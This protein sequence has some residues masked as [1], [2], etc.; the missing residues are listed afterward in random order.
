MTESARRDGAPHDVAWHDVDES[1]RDRRC[2]HCG[3]DA[4]GARYCCYG[5]ELAQQL[6]TE[7]HQ[8]RHATAG[9]LTL[10]LLLAMIVMMMSLF[11]YAEDIYEATNEPVF[12]WLRSFYRWVSAGLATPVVLMLGVPLGRRAW[13]RLT[14]RAIT[15]ELLIV[16]GAV[17]AWLVSMVAVV[18]GA[19]AVY[20]D[21]AVAALVLATFGRYL[22]AKARARA[23]H[24]V[25]HLL[26][27]SARPVRVGDVEMAPAAIEPGME[28][29]VGPEQVVPVDGRLLAPVEVSLGVLTGESSP[30]ALRQGDEVPAGATPLSGE[31]FAVAL[32]PA[33]ASTLEALA[34]LA[35]GL[36]EQRADVQ[37]WADRLA[38]WLTPFVTAIALGALVHWGTTASWPVGI[39]TALAVVLV[40]CPCTYGV[41]TPLIMWL[42]LRK[43]LANGVCIRNA[44]VVEAMAAAE[45]VAFDKTGTLTRP[46][47]AVQMHSHGP[48]TE[49]VA[50]LVASLE[51]D[52]RHPIAG[53]LRA[54][55]GPRAATLTERRIVDGQGIVARDDRGRTVALGSPRLMGAL[56]VDVPLEARGRSALLAVNGELTASFDVD[57]ELRPEVFDVVASLSDAGMSQIILTGDRAPR[58]ARIGELL[59]VQARGELTANDKVEALRSLGG[60]A[61]VVGDGVNDAPASA[62]AATGIAVC[63]ASGLNQG[64]ADVM[65]LRED[66]NLVPWALA[67]SRRASQLARRTLLAATIY[68][69]VFVALAASGVLRPV[70]AGLSMLAASLLALASALR[71]AAH[72]DVPSADA[73]SAPASSSSSAAEEIAL[74]VAA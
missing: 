33:S 1:V 15:M 51:R 66:L 28:F 9:I 7:S 64:L 62:A 36:R 3:L 20:F 31:L 19:T 16:V 34:R 40:A 37:R 46:M 5:C 13:R 59:G 2:D 56:G 11:L 58:A 26:E 68:N 23:S 41:I 49:S 67:L 35:R 57:E 61:V 38:T 6:A 72:P 44:Q 48:S 69:L 25:G 50:P 74:E 53:A 39:E 47:Q 21:S 29:R 65:L 24:L 10:S 73:G 43:A 4:G 18:R 70:W 27:P 71:M 30:V 32:R 22:E 52:H 8:D 14:D 60:R 12:V 17:A 45:I 54:W 55:A 63:G 42:T